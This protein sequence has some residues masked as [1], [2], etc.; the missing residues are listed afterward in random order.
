MQQNQCQN[1]QDCLIKGKK[2]WGFWQ[3]GTCKRITLL[4]NIVTITSYTPV[5]KIKTSNPCAT[6]KINLSVNN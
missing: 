5:L 2:I 6:K 4:E 1:P 3:Q